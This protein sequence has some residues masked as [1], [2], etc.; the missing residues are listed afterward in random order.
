[1]YSVDDLDTVERLTD[2]PKAS[3]GAPCP[4]AVCD[5]SRLYVA[6]Y[7]HRSEPGWNGTSV[8]IVSPATEGEMVALVEF[9]HHYAFM[10]GPPNDD[11]FDGHPLADRG[12]QPYGAF[13]VHQSSWVRRLERMNSVHPHHRPEAFG[14]L[15]HYV[16]AFHDSTVEVV[17]ESYRSSVRPGSIRSA[18]SALGGRLG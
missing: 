17:A 8:R 3:P 13:V 1:M 4:A 12:L 10:F 2:V 5:E 18:I 11:A 15:R 7:L 6:Y 14:S 16:F 9:L